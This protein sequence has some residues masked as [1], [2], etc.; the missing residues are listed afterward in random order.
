LIAG[1]FAATKRA[2]I[3][4]LLTDDAAH[5]LRES[6]RRRTDWRHV[7]SAG[8]KVFEIASADLNGLAPDLQAALQQALHR[9]ATD[10]FRYRYD[11]IRVDESLPPPIEHEDPLIG[12]ARL[13]NANSTI[14]LLRDLAPSAVFNFADAQATRYNTGDFLTRHDD[15]IAGKGRK[16][17]YVLSLSQGW[18]AEWGGL[19]IF[20]DTGGGVAETFVPRFNTL[21]LFAVPQPHSVSYVA[22]YAGEPRLSIT[23]WLRDRTAA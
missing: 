19:L 14:G 13:M 21:S 7:I 2:Q 9:E 15:E 23:G 18:R 4:D 1:R 6:L 17:A 22:P 11:L 12:F 3:P 10:G 8:A 16:L 20:N 5:A